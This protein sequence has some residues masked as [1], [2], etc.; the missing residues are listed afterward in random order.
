M[1]AVLDSS[2]VLAYLWS[3]PGAD[4]V[5]EAM[6]GT[7]VISTVNVAEIASKLDDMVM[8]DAAVRS[9]VLAL[10]ITSVDFDGDQ[11]LLAGQLRRQTRHRG[12]SLGDRA[13]LALALT[14]KGTV[15]TTDRAWLSLELGLEIR[16]TR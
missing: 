3:E 12:L 6:D 2:A 15:Y 4:G 8:D 10:S 13:C 9:V 1:T 16:I 14:Q 5:I 11:A 7:A